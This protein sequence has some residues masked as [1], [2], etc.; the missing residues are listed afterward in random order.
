MR[1]F[2]AV[3]IVFLLVAF[4]L[5]MATSLQWYKRGQSKIRRTITASGRSI[6]AEIP[7]TDGLQFFTE[8]T[9]AFH[10]E[11]RIIP[12]KEIRSTRLLISGAPISVRLS[13]L[14]PDPAPLPASDFQQP[15]SIE[16][17]RW[18]VAIDL[19]DTT[20]VVECGSIRERVSQELAGQVFKAVASDI[21][22]R[23]KDQLPERLT[24]SAQ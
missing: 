10:W 23:E 12:K 19:K 16:R 20:V 6:I 7:G 18:D 1:D 3:L 15:D 4:A 21:E 14:F 24:T 22:L 13:A 17:E 9:Q 2:V 8:D 5:R 11:K